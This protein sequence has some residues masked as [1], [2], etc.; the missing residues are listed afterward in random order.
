MLCSTISIVDFEQ[1]TIRLVY[2]VP[3]WHLFTQSQ[4][5]KRQN[6]M[7]NNF[8]TSNKQTRATSTSK[9]YLLTYQADM[10]FLISCIFIVNLEHISYILQMI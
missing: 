5:W 4:Q 7:L 1:V 8:N 2:F 9:L 6:D 3:S 10:L